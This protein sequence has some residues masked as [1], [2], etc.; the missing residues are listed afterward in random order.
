MVQLMKE[1]KKSGK[2]DFMLSYDEILRFGTRLCFPNDGDLRREFLKEAHCP[3]LTIHNPCSR[4][5][6]VQIF[7]VK[8]KHI[9]SI[10]FCLQ[11][12][13]WD[14]E[15]QKAN[16]RFVGL[17]EIL[18]RVGTLAYRVELSPRLFKIH[19]VFHVSALR[20]YV[21][22]PSH[23][24]ELEPIQM[25]KDLIDEE[26]PILILDVIDKV[27]GYAIAKLVEV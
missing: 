17:F 19:N 4:L 16:L 2:L 3:R 11:S 12:L 9:R 1:V 13:Q 24:V 15:K 25:S 14:S 21:F 20:K 22:Y 10:R 27:L 18:E 5:E 26:V 6:D 23:V 8:A 7:E